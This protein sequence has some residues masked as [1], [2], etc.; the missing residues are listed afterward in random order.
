MSRSLTTIYKEAVTARDNYL[1]LTELE[2]AYLTSSKVS[3]LNLITYMVAVVIY[4]YETV[5]DLFEIDITT[6]LNQ[7][8]VGTANYYA[9]MAKL[10]QY[11][12]ATQMSDTLTLN[13]TTY[14]MEYETVNE[15]HRII[16][17]VACQQDKNDDT[18]D[19]TLKVCKANGDS[20]E[21]AAL[22]TPLTDRELSCFQSYINDIKY[23]GTAIQC[24]SYPGDILTVNAL[25]YYDSQN[26]LGDDIMASVKEALINYA[27]GLEYNENVYYK[28]VIG[29]IEGVDGVNYT[30]SSAT[31]SLTSY[32]SGNNAYGDTEEITTVMRPVSG[33]LT[34]ADENGDSTLT[35]GV[36]ASEE[37]AEQSDVNIKII[38][39]KD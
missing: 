24:V 36:F 35:L 16:E 6:L 3:I 11:N 12:D 7:R 5:L 29:A 32:S 2:P 4:S 18:Y 1:Q 8:M 19:L 14:Q 13:T 25:V 26:H 37:E 15:D 28:K 39:T 20:S 33:Y 22:Y 38:P 27:K 30:D 23:V 9:Y 21:E 10:F 17:K 31:V 34:F